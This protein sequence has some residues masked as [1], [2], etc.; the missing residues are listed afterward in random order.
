MGENG[1]KL[2]AEKRKADPKAQENRTVISNEY[3]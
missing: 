1:R 3:V 2:R